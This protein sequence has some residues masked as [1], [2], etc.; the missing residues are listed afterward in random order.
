MSLGE[1]ANP[2]PLFD[3]DR[4][5]EDRQDRPDDHKDP[6]INFLISDTEDIRPVDQYC[7]TPIE[8]LI[9]H[10]CLRF[11][12][13]THFMMSELSKA[14][15]HSQVLISR[16]AITGLMSSLHESPAAGIVFGYF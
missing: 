16:R 3:D 7:H 1:L 10:R 9:H 14:C 12:R 2:L 15:I 13:W 5:H 4:G 8:N 11:L 6:H